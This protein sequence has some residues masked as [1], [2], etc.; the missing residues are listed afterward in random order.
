MKYRIVEM[1]GLHK[2]QYRSFSIP[3]IFWSDF[4]IW[5]DLIEVGKTRVEYYGNQDVAKR[6]LR[7]IV[8]KNGD[9]WKVVYEVR[10]KT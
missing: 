4:N 5:S 9:D 6:R 1:W 2:I 7:E 3:F 10:I 8:K